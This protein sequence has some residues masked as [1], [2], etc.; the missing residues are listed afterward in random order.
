MDV[1]FINAYIEKMKST[2]DDFLGKN[3][4]METQL[5]LAQQQVQLQLKEI[6]ELK[7]KIDTL[8]S[9]VSRK[10]KKSEEGTF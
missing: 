5:Q 4:I 8:T 9:K 7:S 10:E 3:L 6:D 1:E 2:L